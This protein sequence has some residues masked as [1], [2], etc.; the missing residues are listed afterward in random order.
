MKL[1]VKKLLILTFVMSFTVNL[2]AQSQVTG[3]VKDANTQKVLQDVNIIVVGTT[4]ATVTDNNGQYTLKINQAQPFTISFSYVGYRTEKVEVTSNKTTINMIMVEEAILQQEIVVL[5][6]RMKEN[7]MKSPVTIEKLNI[8]SIK[9]AA[10][11]DYY[12]ALANMKGVQVTSSSLT[13]TSVNTRGFAG[14]GNTRFVQLIDGMDIADPTIGWAV[15]SV[16]APGELDIESLE[17]IPGAASALYGPNAF[18]GIMLLQSKSP[19]DY[20]GLSTMV[21]QGVTNSKAGGTDPMGTYAIR[22]AKIFNDKV[23]FKVNFH[24]LNATDWTANDNKTDRNNPSSEIDLSGMP[25]FDGVNL[26]G[27]E[28]PIPINNFG[29]GT[30]RRTGFSENILLDN[31]EARVLKG[32]IAIHYKINNKMELIGAARFAQASALAQSDVKFAFRRYNTQ[33]YKLELKSDQFFV[34][35]YFTRTVALNSYNLGALGAYVNESY[36]PSIRADGT[37]WVPD[38]ITAF[39]GGAPGVAANNHPAARSYADRFMIN[40]TTGQYVASLQNTIDEVRSNY[41]Q[42]NPPG[43]GFFSSANLWQTDLYYNFKQI[44]WAEVIAGGNFR[45][46]SVFSKG[47]VFDDAPEDQNNANPLMTNSY[48]VYT[49]IAKS[50]TE[51]LKV[52]T[53]IRYDEMKDFEGRFTPRLSMVYSPNKNHNVRASYQT[54]FRFPELISQFIYFNNPDGII[55]GGVPSIASRYGVYNGG[56]WTKE[57]YDNFL[58]QGGSLNPT[59]G[60]ILS[61]PG[62][63]TLETANVSFIKAEQQQTFEIGYKGILVGD[64]LFDLNYYYSTYT[65]FAGTQ[66]VVG[67]VSTTHQGAQ[68]NA[69]QSW[70]LATN[71]P[72]ELT[73]YGV[74]LGLTYNLNRNFVLNG[75]Y[76]YT[77]FSG[78][79]EPGFLAQF[80]TPENRFSIGV[81]NQKLTRNLGFNLNY[82]YQQAFH[83]ESLFGEASIPAFGVL[84]AQV[85]YTLTSLKTILKIGGTNLGG[86]DYRTS[87][88]SPYVGQIYY[89]SLVFDELLK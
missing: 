32:D 46:M 21:K 33:V 86:K 60:A 52:T 82:R 5:S 78:Q 7:I 59:T 55:L 56:A 9:Q 40:P 19:F 44:K 85:N 30:L 17:L 23:A 3:T 4:V 89:I 10:T 34:R 87:F 76:N 8:I 29:I 42:R 47:T 36:N 69:G 80:N 48:G 67:K 77:T 38:Y 1:I 18:N 15:G 83:W 11:P 75:N 43:A 50:I 54:G 31:Q 61:N 13:N 62:N 57:S 63:V 71:S 49:Q 45:Y 25:D 58:I 79:L 14:T 35:N 16:M 24:F 12:D 65:D 81:G 26:Q 41:F 39:L 66:V 20:P 73:S 70:V 27:D 64:L 28:A 22:Y 72:N 68:V 88:G 2:F 53:S 37:G 6:S 74:G 84:D 51:K